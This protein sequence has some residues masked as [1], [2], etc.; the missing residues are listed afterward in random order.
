[1]AV[2]LER[3][4]AKSEKKFQAK[5]IVT[6]CWYGSIK[7]FFSFTFAVFSNG[8]HLDKSLFSFETTECKNG[9]C[10]SLFR[11]HL[12]GID[13]LLFL[14]L[15]YFSNDRRRPSWSTKMQKVKIGF[16]QRSL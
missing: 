14:F 5:I 16:M 6:Q 8:S 3:K 15:C 2:I 10:T 12:V 11:I 1:M 7:L 4:I 9:F 13:I